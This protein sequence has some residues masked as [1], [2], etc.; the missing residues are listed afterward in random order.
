M[1]FDEWQK[2]KGEGY[3]KKKIIKNKIITNSEDFISMFYMYQ[4]ILSSQ[5]VYNKSN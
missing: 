1:P 4:N 5:S 2:K 3:K